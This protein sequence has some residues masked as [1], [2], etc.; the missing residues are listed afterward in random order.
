MRKI[1]SEYLKLFLNRIFVICL[2]VA[3]LANSMF[4]LMTQNE[5]IENSAIASDV[6]VY[7][8][9]I[10][11]C[12]NSDDK[13]AFIESK[14]L[15][16]Q[17]ALRLLR[18]AENGEDANVDASALKYKEEHPEEFSKASEL[19]LTAEELNNLSMMLNDISSQF[20]YIESYDEFISNMK[21]RAEEQ[22]GFAIFAKPNSFSYKNIQKTPMDFERVANVT[23]TL[24]NNKAL[25]VSTT[26]EL[27]DYL[28][29]VLI[30]LVCIAVFT[31]ER[32]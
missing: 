7:E 25:E 3:L 32:E 16:I 31:V 5:N 26:F 12:A 15:E 8:A 11:E 19:N 27:T 6:E 13:E 4:L 24:G 9:L 28:L 1:S 21:T 23:P 30:L 20:A 10:T 2:C 22:S 18:L 14:Y 17:I 29:L